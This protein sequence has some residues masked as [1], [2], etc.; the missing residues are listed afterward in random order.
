MNSCSID[1]K[2]ILEADSSISLVY[3]TDLF[4]AQE[5]KTPKNTVTIFEGPSS[6][7]ML[8]FKKGE[9]YYYDAVQ[10]RIRNRKF[11]TGYALATSIRDVLHGYGQVTVNGTLYTVIYCSSGPAEM[12]YDDNG[13][14][15]FV[16]NFEIQRR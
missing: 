5:P 9:N 8:T 13:R 10:V 6:A 15:I 16:M 4:V 12:G 14:I 3:G 2:D 1:I 11:T 7:P